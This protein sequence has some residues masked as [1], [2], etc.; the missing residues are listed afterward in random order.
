MQVPP[1]AVHHNSHM[2]EPRYVQEVM[3]SPHH[4]IDS[5]SSA[6]THSLRRPIY[7][8]SSS[9]EP[10]HR[11]VGSLSGS[12]LDSPHYNPAMGRSA[13][14]TGVPV[15]KRHL[16]GYVNHAFTHQRKGVPAHAQYVEVTPRKASSV[17]GVP[18]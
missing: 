17:V 6:A 9:A 8:G 18:R 3:L 4:H 14:V 1:T 10:H 7:A 12:G 13:S 16:N 2:L 11:Y 15:S 5:D